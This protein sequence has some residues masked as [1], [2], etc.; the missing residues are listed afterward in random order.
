MIF[1]TAACIPI[2]YDKFL[3]YWKLTF[4]GNLLVD[5]PGSSIVVLARSLWR[6]AAIWRLAVDSSYC[7]RKWISSRLS[8]VWE[9]PC[10]VRPYAST[11]ITDFLSYLGRQL[12]PTCST[13]SDYR[14]ASAESRCTWAKVASDA[15]PPV[16]LGPLKM[17]N[18][19][20]PSN[21]YLIRE[22]YDA[23]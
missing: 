13:N 21:L 9:L 22:I 8:I 14:S 2:Q 18:D 20:F 15:T 17:S 4:E 1:V 19:Y 3:C 6:I 23:V 12:S 7:R 16:H 11:R 5:Y 10:P